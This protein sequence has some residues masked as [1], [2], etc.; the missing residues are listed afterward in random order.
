MPRQVDDLDGG[1]IELPEIVVVEVPETIICDEC[2]IGF[3]PMS[4]SF[5]CPACG[6]EN[7][8]FSENDTAEFDPLPMSPELGGDGGSA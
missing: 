3:F 8:S 4:D 5:A 2:G 6:M 1:F 7:Y